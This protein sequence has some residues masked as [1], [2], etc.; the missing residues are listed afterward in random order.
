MVEVRGGIERGAVL[1]VRAV[2]VDVRVVRD[3]QLHDGEVAG[4]KHGLKRGA[5]LA[6]GL[7]V[8]VCAGVEEE[9]GDGA[10]AEEGGRLEC[11]LKSRASQIAGDKRG[12]LLL[13]TTLS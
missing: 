11:V 9:L 1:G 13:E 4:I 2:G 5:V 7:E 6:V 10:V 8:D 12:R 3:G